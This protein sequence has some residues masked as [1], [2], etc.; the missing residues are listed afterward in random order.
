MMKL[1]LSILLSFLGLAL[2]CQPSTT[3]ES[4]PPPNIIWLVA[5]DIS[6]ALGAYG[7]SLAN[8]P[9]L[10][11]LAKQSVIFD[12]AYA[13]APICAPARTCLITGLYATS[14][15]SQ[16][17][18]CEITLPEEVQPFPLYLKEAGLGVHSPPIPTLNSGSSI[19]LS[20][21]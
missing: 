18:R 21:K 5:E 1:P 16:H 20:S 17:L 6:P 10:D 8:T 9:N 19:E 7:D 13:T 2:S 12:Q 4:L 15:G 3:T 14:L 11:R